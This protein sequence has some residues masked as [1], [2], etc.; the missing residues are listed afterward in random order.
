MTQPPSPVA[1]DAVILAGGR[2]SR[3]GGTSKADLVVGGGRL[4]D[5]VLAA[6][7]GARQRVVVGEVE[8][9]DGVLLTMEDPP[10]GG[11]A[12]GLVAGLEALGAAAAKWTLVLACDLPGAAEV[13]P[14]LLT[15]AAS[16]RRDGVVITAEGRVQWLTA[17]YRTDALRAAAEAYGDPHQGSVRGLLR[18]LTLDEVADPAGASADVDTWADHERW[19]VRLRGEEN[20]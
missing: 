15:A 19:S 6:A 16:T 1:F 10:R 7:S 14:A 13:V 3:L 11:P 5:R 9:P 20:G 4:L 2:G 12:A 18:P 8:V 17:L